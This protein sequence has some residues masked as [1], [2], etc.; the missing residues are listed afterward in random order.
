M[1]NCKLKFIQDDHNTIV[2]KNS[3]LNDFWDKLDFKG[4][5]KVFEHD[6]YKDIYINDDL[7]TN[8]ISKK[9]N[10]QNNFR[11]LYN[12]QLYKTKVEYNPFYPTS[13][14]FFWEMISRFKIN[15]NCEKFLFVD[16]GDSNNLGH[17]EATMK[18]CE[19]NF[20]YEKNEYIRLP[21]GKMNMSEIYK[22]FS[23]IYSNHK[24]FSF[25]QKNCDEI[26][27]KKI[28]NYYKNY[29]FNCSIATSHNFIQNLLS[30]HA[31]N[32]G[33]NAIIFIKDLFDNQYDDVIGF[34]NQIFKKVI[35]Y[36]PEIQN[37]LDYSCWLILINLQK[38]DRKVIEDII[39]T[40][41]ISK[42]YL[43]NLQSIRTIFK[44]NLYDKLLLLYSNIKYDESKCLDLEK[45]NPKSLSW[46]NKYNVLLQTN[47]HAIL[48]KYNQVAQ[49]FKQFLFSGNNTTDIQSIYKANFD[50]HHIKRSLNEYKRI[51][52]TKEQ[53][54]DNDYDYDIIDWNKLTDCIDLHKNLKK[55]ITWKF[56]A[57]FVNNNWLKF[58]ELVS[59]LK[60]FDPS[61]DKVKTFSFFE[62]SGS[63]IMALNHYF[64]TILNKNYEW[65]A[66]Y[67]NY[68]E[69]FIGRYNLLKN[70]SENW[71]YD[72]NG[73]NLTPQIIN[74]YLKN[75]RLK[76]IDLII[77]DISVKIPKD[78]FNEQEEFLSKYVYSQLFVAL[79]ILPSGNYRSLI[80][81]LFLPLVAYKTITIIY[82]LTVLFKE[83]KIVKP[84][85]SHL[86]SSEVYCVATGY[87][88]FNKID[89]T[90]IEKMESVYLDFNNDIFE[91]EQIK[92][93]FIKELQNI[94]TSLSNNQI[95]AIKRSLYLRN[96]YYYDYDI[97]NDL[98]R[99]KEYF[100]ET[101]IEKN[102]IIPI[103][104]Q[105]KIS[106]KKIEI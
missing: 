56:N 49:E 2:K 104:D 10:I 41:N 7:L 80:I 85:T 68:K 24:V 79:N 45:S 13:Y 90:L 8:I 43:T 103:K 33:G 94:S 74:N 14:Y 78:K 6:E 34:L 63:S 32:D 40:N 17:I 88:G 77:S 72:F 98:T 86:S 29:K 19:T 16:D 54:I 75:D 57:E 23:E 9:I 62:T 61:K 25:T 3:N 100:I 106:H 42:K 1:L 44:I 50:L 102:K 18:H 82:L 52:D 95:L 66:Q 21:L 105:D 27:I 55:I 48:D 71:I 89:H 92:D 15:T 83:V 22:A 53:F 101:W 59:N 46:A 28:V 26:V 11:I 20:H 31:L 64:K 70:Y 60:L 37:T 12:D 84:T 97:Q 99:S 69:K 96:L 35:I 39:L 91:K 67:P 73:N 30:I 51:I 87:C 93:N 4:K 76:D 81:K 58:Y 47:D 5:E 38:F 36:K 65:Y